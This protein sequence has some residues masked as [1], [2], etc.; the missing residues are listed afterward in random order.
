MQIAFTIA[1][2]C[3]NQISDGIDV[4]SFIESQHKLIELHVWSCKF[5]YYVNMFYNIIITLL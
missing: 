5:Q 3:V 2:T 4:A 1:V